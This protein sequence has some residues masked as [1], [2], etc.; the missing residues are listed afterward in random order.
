MPKQIPTRDKI[1]ALAA[2]PGT[3]AEGR[4]ATAKLAQLP[5]PVPERERLTEA[6]IKSLPVPA[7]GQRIYFDMPDGRGFGWVPGFGIRVTSGGARAYVLNY[8]T[9]TGRSGRVTIGSPPEWSL[10]AARK[11]AEELKR[12]VDQGGD[13]VREVR[14]RREADNVNGLLDRFMAEH[15]SKRRPR[16]KADYRYALDK[17]VRPVLGTRKVADIS[18]SDIDRLHG[19]IKAKFRANRVIAILHKAFALAQRWGLY[20]QHLVN[21]CKGVEKNDE[22]PRERYLTDDEYQRLQKVLVDYDHADAVKLTKLVLFSG[23]RITRALT[24]E[25]AQFDLAAGTWNQVYVS[26]NKER[27]RQIPL[28]APAL[29]LLHV[30]RK[31]APDAK[32]VFDLHYS[33]AREHFQRI[34]V[35]AGIPIKGEQRVTFHTLRHSLASTLGNAGQSLQVIGKLLGH[36]DQKTT[37]RY[38]HLVTDTLRAATERASAIITGKAPADVV[39][40]KEAR[41]GST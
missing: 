35:A 5:A 15:V 7:A 14:E 11:R 36:H 27:A 41:R 38:S 30:M 12:D 16:T 1:K 34:M 26:K 37:A 21:P 24:A 29:D 17:H 8:R 9:K 33:Q 31:D 10:T 32:K 20:P 23:Q 3:P 28:S 4:A 25:W 18:H 6:L 13:P 22:P 2:R 19:S 40:L 39:P